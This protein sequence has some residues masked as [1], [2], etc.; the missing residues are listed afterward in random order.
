MTSFADF[1]LLQMVI[2]R[3]F[4]IHLRKPFVGEKLINFFHQLNW[5]NGLILCSGMVMMSCSDLA[6]SFVLAL[7][8]L[9]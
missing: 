9:V 1:T 5:K 6:L 8:V 2:F 3:V 4:H 7:P